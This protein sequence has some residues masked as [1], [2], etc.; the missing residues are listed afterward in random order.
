MIL[1]RVECA[2]VATVK[3]EHLKNCKIL[4]CRPVELDGQTSAGPAF[5]A[6]DRVQAGE[7]DLVL[8]INEGS[9]TRLVF[10]DPKIP[11]T[12]F[13]AAVV[14]DLE[15]ID[16]DSLVGASVAEQALAQGGKD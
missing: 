15:V 5:L 13:I 14:D 11:L 1:C 2:A 3:N 10:G 9:S 7:G 16:E 4:S 6:V 12:A 8:V